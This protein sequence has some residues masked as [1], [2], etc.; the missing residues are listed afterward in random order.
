MMR[1]LRWKLSRCKPYLVGIP[2]IAHLVHHGVYFDEPKAKFPTTRS[3]TPCR[4]PLICLGFIFDESVI[5]MSDLDSIPPSTWDILNRTFHLASTHSKQSFPLTPNDTPPHSARMSSPITPSRPLVL[6]ID[7]LWPINYHSSHINLAQAM[8]IAIKL[9]PH[10]TYITDMTHP[11][12][13]FMWEEICRSISGKDGHYTTEEG[14]RWHPD[15]DATRDVVKKVWSDPQFQGDAGR[16][17]KSWGGRVEPGWD[18]LV[19]QVRDGHWSLV[20]G[21]GGTAG[22]WG[23]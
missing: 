7:V 23:I 21:A 5:Y 1:L 17:I 6:I 3:V 22:G 4:R 14:D 20:E 8:E 15:A 12:T 9:N 19:L 13:H 18:G 11:T 2:F 16:R 10:M